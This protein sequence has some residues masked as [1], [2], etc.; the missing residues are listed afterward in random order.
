[1]YVCSL[2]HAYVHC[3]GSVSNGKFNS[4]R[5]KG[6]TRPISMFAVRS[7]V[8]NKYAKMSHKVMAS[9]LIYPVSS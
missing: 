6:Y 3:V 1:M 9:M 2:T 5:A 4:L 8:Q 7:Q